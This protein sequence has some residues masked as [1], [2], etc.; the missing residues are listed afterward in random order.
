MTK[1]NVSAQEKLIQNTEN[2]NNLVSKYVVSPVARLGIAG[3]EFDIFTQQ[4][5]EIR[6]DITDHF[7]E[8]N[9]TRQDHIALPAKMYTLRGF[10][11]ELK[12]E[13]EAEKN[14]FQEIG[15]KLTTL[16]SYLPI[17]TNSAKQVNNL[18][19]GE[20]E[21]T[22]QTVDES[23]E[24]GINLFQAYKQLNPPDTAQAKAYNFFVALRDGKQLVSVDTPF[25]FVPD[26]AIENI[27]AVQDNNKYIMDFTVTLKEFRKVST[28]FAS[29]DPK[30]QK[31]QGRAENQKAEER[32]QGQAN[33]EKKLIS[34]IKDKINKG[35]ASISD[36]F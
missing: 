4:K 31:S 21:S 35:I 7:V 3:F 10:V 11:G 16:N 22:A 32:D 1:E 23:V 5:A 15:Q 29:F 36:F 24:A 17:V 8:D 9:S 33:G 2:L 13:P 26:L 14:K 12:T 18:L 27:I 30:K 19:T 34:T 6:S 25:G 28:E 20:K